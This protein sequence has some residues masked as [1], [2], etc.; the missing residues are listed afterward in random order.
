[1]R[2]KALIVL[3]LLLGSC[4]VRYAIRVQGVIYNLK[5]S[6]FDLAREAVQKSLKKG[7]LLYYLELGTV[8]HYAR[9]YRRS[10]D[11]FEK[12]ENL[13]EELYTRSLTKEAGAVLTSENIKPYRGED[14]EDVLI[15]YY[16]AFNYYFLGDIQGAVV[17]ARKVDQKLRYLNDH[18]EK[19]NTYR[20][21]AFMEFLSGVFHEMAG[22]YNDA[23]ISYD[24]SYKTYRTDYAINYDTDVPP[25]LLKAIKRTQLKTG[26]ERYREELDT[27]EIHPERSIL[28]VVL[29]YGFIPPK[30]EASIE[31]SYQTKKGIWKYRRIAIPVLPDTEIIVPHIHA[32]A[33]KYTLRFYEV[34]PIYR[35]AARNLRDKTLR[36]LAKAALRATV[37]YEVEK[38]IEKELKKKSN[39]LGEVA[40][41]FL[42]FLNYSTERA[43]TREW[44]TLPATVLAS[45]IEL[46]PGVYPVSVTVGGQRIFYDSVKVNGIKLIKIR[47][48]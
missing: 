20:D 19:K 31:F 30:Q 23:L 14:Y 36:I 27:V 2:K 35:I 40:G 29:E 28:I 38:K 48:F 32:K 6:N 7:S 13:R 43:D 3:F 1:M 25:F 44:A 10:S 24:K 33:G 21:D 39:T 5:T 17:E 12:A 15:N 34:E 37:K 8:E 16:K 46:D 41:I 22:E 47:K 18:Y 45:Y 42:N 26:I 4:T 11:L 9:N